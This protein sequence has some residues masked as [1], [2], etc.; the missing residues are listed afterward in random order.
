MAGSPCGGQHQFDF[1][2][3][4]VLAEDATDPTPI[5]V[6]FEHDLGRS[7]QVMAEIFLQDHHDKFHWRE[8]VIQEQDLV[9]PRRL[10]FLGLTLDG[11]GAVEFISTWRTGR[12]HRG[13]AGKIWHVLILFI[14]GR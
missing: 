14:E 4:N 6:D 10:S 3:C 11:G 13:L 7:I 9:E 8:I 2:R 5:V 1:R 12:W